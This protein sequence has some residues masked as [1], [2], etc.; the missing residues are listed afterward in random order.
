MAYKLKLSK[1]YSARGADMGRRADLPAD[2]ATAAPLLHLTKMQMIEQGDYDTG[3]AYWGANV[4]GEV[5]DMY[6]AEDTTG[7]EYVRLFIR[8]FDREGAKAQV[9]KQI[10][11]ARF[12]R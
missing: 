4:F 1:G 9:L 8:D 7:D 2:C 3:G 5:G 10:P 12:Y 11:H 6:C